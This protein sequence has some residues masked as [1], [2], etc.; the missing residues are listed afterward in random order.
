[1]YMSGHP[2]CWCIVWYDINRK[3]Y[4]GGNE[5]LSYFHHSQCLVHL[6]LSDL[7]FSNAA[8]TSSSSTSST[9]MD[10]YTLA[11]ELRRS[12]KCFQKSLSQARSQSKLQFVPQESL[13]MEN[14]EKGRIQR[15]WPVLIAISGAEG[16]EYL[17]KCQQVLCRM[18]LLN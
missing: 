12:A 14:A 3:Q 1:M 11:M 17:E 13:E 2:S 16:V 7:N 15:E 9:C 8:A 5:A 10:G 6:V 18:N 4:L